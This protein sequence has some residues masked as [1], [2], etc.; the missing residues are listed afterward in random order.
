MRILTD[1][2]LRCRPTMKCCDPQDIEPLLDSQ[3]NPVLDSSGNPIP[4][5]PTQRSKQLQQQQQSGSQSRYSQWRQAS[6]LLGLLPCMSCCN[7]IAWRHAM[8]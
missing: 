4:K 1:P 3:G 6:A 8:M 2:K 7:L 5:D